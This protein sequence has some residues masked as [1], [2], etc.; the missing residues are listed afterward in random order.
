MKTDRSTRKGDIPE[1]DAPAKG[2]FRIR[3]SKA[4]PKTRASAID[5]DG[6]VVETVPVADVPAVETDTT[7]RAAAAPGGDQPAGEASTATPKA[8]KP[9]RVLPTVAEALSTAKAAN[10]GRYANVIEVTEL[11]KDGEPKRVVIKCSDPQTKHD[12]GGQVVSVCET[13]REIAV[14]D[15]FQ[16]Q[17]CAACAERKVRIARRDRAK[18]KNKALRAAIKAAKQ[19]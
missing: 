4:N 3:E 9:A 5:G 19:A 18:R 10:P 8:S 7:A 12:A 15:L 17:C 2:R 11:T 6:K 14:Q 1:T 13:T 16:V